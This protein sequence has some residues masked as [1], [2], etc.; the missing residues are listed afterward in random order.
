ML[1]LLMGCWPMVMRVPEAAA[2]AVGASAVRQCA[3][4]SVPGILRQHKGCLVHL[5]VVVPGQQHVGK[6][7]GQPARQQ[8]ITTKPLD[9]VP[10]VTS[11]NVSPAGMQGCRFPLPKPRQLAALVL[12]QS[13]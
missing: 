4:E 1:A 5:A 10:S 12:Y 7:T 11:T 3:L 13:T 9:G 2:Q 8:N 6:Q